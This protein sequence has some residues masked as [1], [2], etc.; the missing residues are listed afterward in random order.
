MNTNYTAEDF[1]KDIENVSKNTATAAPH[2]VTLSMALAG[3]GIVMKLLWNILV[4]QRRTNELLA[5]LNNWEIT[6]WQNRN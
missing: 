2:S 3:L 6:K 1:K 5:E 4:E